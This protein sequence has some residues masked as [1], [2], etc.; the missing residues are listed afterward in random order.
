MTNYERQLRLMSNPV[1]QSEYRLYFTQAAYDWRLFKLWDHY[2][3][4]RSGAAWR[5]IVRRAGGLE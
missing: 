1:L 4:A 5:E 3:W 2:K